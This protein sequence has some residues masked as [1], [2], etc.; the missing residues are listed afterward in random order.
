MTKPT[1][2]LDRAALPP[3]AT[4]APGQSSGSVAKVEP[5]LEDPSPITLRMEEACD[6][7]EIEHTHDSD[8]PGLLYIQGLIQESSACLVTNLS[9]GQSRT[10]YQPQMV[11]TLGRHREAAVPLKDQT[12][13]RQHAVIMY[14]PDAGFFLIDLNSMNGTYVNNQ[15]IH[16][17]YRLKDGDCIHLGRLKINFFVSEL[18]RSIWPIPP[19][20]LT[21][22]HPTDSEPDRLVKFCALDETLV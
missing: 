7:T 4:T 11:W 15:R 19:E 6:F 8:Q 21:R 18:S 20:T 17:R 12:L 2:V 16:Q 1:P 22:L 10:L 5:Q 3:I 9:E 14:I 13:S